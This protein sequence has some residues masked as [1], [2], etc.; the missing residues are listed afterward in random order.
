MLQCVDRCVLEFVMMGVC[1]HVCVCVYI[2]VCDD[3]SM[4]QSVQVVL[5]Q[6]GGGVC[7]CYS[8]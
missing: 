4:S 7:M 5:S 1:M 2:T 8:V 3:A 6:C